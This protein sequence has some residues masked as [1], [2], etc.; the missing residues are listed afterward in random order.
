MSPC[1]LA[2]WHASL[3]ASWIDYQDVDC[4]ERARNMR[5]RAYHLRAALSIL[6]WRGSRKVRTEADRLLKLLEER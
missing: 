2:N 1:A 6:K 3:A 5:E 4:E